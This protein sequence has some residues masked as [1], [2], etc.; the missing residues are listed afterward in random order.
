MIATMIAGIKKFKR[1]VPNPKFENAIA[2]NTTRTANIDPQVIPTIL[3]ALGGGL[4]ILFPPW[5]W[6]GSE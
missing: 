2:G 4:D 6:L 3:P 5:K 1:P